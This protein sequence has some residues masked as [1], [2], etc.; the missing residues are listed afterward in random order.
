MELADG[1]VGSF[2]L[3]CSQSAAKS[4]HLLMGRPHPSFRTTLALCALTACGGELA[5]LKGVRKLGAL[6]AISVYNVLAA[7]VLTVPLYYLFGDTAIVPSLVLMAL[8]QLLLPR[9]VLSA[10]SSTRL[11]A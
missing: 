2:Y 5:I 1:L 3:R 7:L 8:V 6:A 10:L 9:R 11:L 4:L